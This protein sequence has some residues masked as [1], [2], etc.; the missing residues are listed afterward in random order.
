MTAA[1]RIDYTYR[2]S[3]PSQLIREGPEWG[4][5]LATFG[6]ISDQATAN[7]YFFEGELRQPQTFADLLLGVARVVTSRFFLPAAM[8]EYD[9]VVTS[10]EE[11]LRFEGFSS[12]C[13]VYAR[14][15]LPAESFTRAIQG[16]GTTNVDFNAPMRAALARLRS[17]DRVKLA[18]GADEV[19]LSQSSGSVVE[20]KV[21]LPVRWVKGFTEVQAYQPALDKRFEVSSAEALRFIRGLPRGG[22]PK[23]PSWVTP[24]GPGL[25][26]SQRESNGGVRV[27]GTDRLRVLEPL[28]SQAKRLQVWANDTTSVSGWEV[29]NE[30]GQFFLMISPDVWRGFSGEGQVL[31]TL[32]GKEWQAAL[33]QVR[34]ALRWQAK[35]NAT[36]IAKDAGLEL[37]EV[38]AALA[39]LGARGLVGFDLNQG[40]YFHRELPFDMEKV[41]SLQPR[42]KDA[43]QLLEEKKARLIKQSGP[44]DAV[45]A[46]VGV[47]G[48]EVEHRVRLTPQGDKCT[49]PWYS[50]HGGERGPCKHILAA[51]LLIQGDEDDT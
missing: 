47:Q 21:T 29:T 23:N 42:L 25:R 1:A 38:Q 4:L 2:Y 32:A 49:C 26:L 6:G 9:P 39:V 44:S 46:E 11:V 40:G 7:P 37:K 28:L 13:G 5:R 12:C 48:T 31:K 50:K 24:Q 30:A 14:A 45:T 34:A 51:R 41:E 8:I 35:I 17:G 18:V 3:Y 16:R 27:T 22:A 15:D 43:R 36:Q 19:R 10:S 33:P 20:K